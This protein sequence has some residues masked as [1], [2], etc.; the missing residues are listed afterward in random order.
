[1][2]EIAVPEKSLASITG[3]EAGRQIDFNDEHL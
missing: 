1:M 2:Y 3:N